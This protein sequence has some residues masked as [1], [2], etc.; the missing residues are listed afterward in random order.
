MSK[1]EIRKIMRQLRRDLGASPDGSVHAAEVWTKFALEAET[2]HPDSNRAGL[3]QADAGAPSDAGNGRLALIAYDALPGELSLRTFL[4]GV[5]ARVWRP[6]VSEARGRRLADLPV[7]FAPEGGRGS[8]SETAGGGGTLADGSTGERSTN[9]GTLVDGGRPGALDGHSKT[10]SGAGSGPDER[11]AF[12]DAAGNGGTLA[13]E[14]AMVFVPALAVDEE[15]V[16]LGQGGGWYDRALRE[17]KWR[18]P[19]ALVF[20]C[21]PEGAYLEAGLLPEEQHDIRMDGVITNHGWRLFQR[22]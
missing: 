7:G 11:E 18:A 17:V 1:S 15:G 9:S 10:Q 14:A 13:V 6:V 16:R 19:G 2:E 3:G 8:R 21:V 20:A 4:D 12:A 22:G 5:D